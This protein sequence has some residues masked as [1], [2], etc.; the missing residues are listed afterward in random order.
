[1][2]SPGTEIDSAWLPWKERKGTRDE[3]QIIMDDNARCWM[4]FDAGSTFRELSLSDYMAIKSFN[5]L[6]AID[7]SI[8][9][10]MDR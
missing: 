2:A 3:P 7:S 4:I 6:Y 5:R 9:R 1:M 10:F 8:D